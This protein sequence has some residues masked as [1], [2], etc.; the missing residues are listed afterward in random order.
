MSFRRLLTLAGQKKVVKFRRPLNINLGVVLFIVIFIYIGIQV[1]LFLGSEQLSVYKVTENQISDDDT[2]HGLI[3]RDETVFRNKHAG[4][5][6]Y[7][8]AEGKKVGKGTTVYTLDESGDMYNLLSNSEQGISLSSSEIAE[9]R[10]SISNFQNSYDESDYESAYN[11]KYDIDS[12]V[13]EVTN[14]NTLNTLHELLKTSTSKANFSVEKAS[15]SG[16]ISYYTDGFEGVTLDTIE[17]SMFDLTK[18]E[19]KQLRSTEIKET[20][21]PVYKLINSEKWSIVTP[22]TENQY[23]KL[24]E[25]KTVRLTFLS[26]KH[27]ATASIS[28]LDKN[29]KKYAVIQMSNYLSR[30]IN[31]RFISFEIGT[32]KATGYKIPVT[33]ICEK[34]F[35]KIPND[36][37]T[38]GG[39]DNSYGIVKLTYSKNGEASTEFIEVDIF[40]RDENFSY[41]DTAIITKDDV[42][43]LP[44]TSGTDNTYKVSETGTLTGVFNV[45]KGYPVFRRIEVLYENNEYCLVAM[46]T[47]LGLNNYDHIIVNVKLAKEQNYV[48]Y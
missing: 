7:Y 2:Y 39:N 28:F 11:Y 38:K 8:V 44:G 41:I 30:Y 40:N 21:A 27:Q 5:I 3:L 24:S 47:S 25:K 46:D 6:N 22:I 32:N 36:Y 4:Y 42:L 13:L 1:Y 10:K 12:T 43:L 33:S 34:D 26:D 45:N 9:I 37:I 18:Y 48:Q 35:Y 31:E 23:K 15:S 14:V 20:D 29:N 19:K 17:D 16:I